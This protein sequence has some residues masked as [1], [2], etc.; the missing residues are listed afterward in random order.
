MRVVESC[1]VAM[2]AVAAC[3]TAC[4]ESPFS[5]VEVEPASRS[6]SPAMPAVLA[7]AAFGPASRVLWPFTGRDFEEPSDPINIIFV[8]QSDPLSLR[9]ALLGLDGDRTAFGLPPASPF[10][11]TWAD[12]IG[13]AQTAFS[14]E[15]GWAGS[16]V[17][18]DCGGYGPL[19]FHLRLFR[20]G[21]WT[22]GGAHFEVL[23]PGTADH[24]VL[25]WELAEQLVVL[26]FMRSGILDPSVPFGA[27]G[28]I[29]PAPSYR[30][31]NPLI[32]NG[33]P[34]ALAAVLGTPP[35]PAA[36]PVPIPNNGVATILNV[37]T[38][39]P[40]TAGVAEQAF[41]LMY[42]VTAP[43]P[44]CASGPQDFIHI[45]GPVSL[46]QTVRVTAAGEYMASARTTGILDV[47]VPGSPSPA[48]TADVDRSTRSLITP[49]G[50][51]IRDRFLQILR[52]SDG[53]TLQSS[54][55][56][57]WLGPG[58]GDFTNI[59]HCN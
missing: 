22:L 20:V 49:A 3:V 7:P 23:I 56:T 54:D 31:I 48:R 52:P 34:A 29:S 27:T 45:R 15:D 26:D 44:F 43:R 28:A 17:Q 33:I 18:L 1:G 55:A 58:G 13:S 12:A 59:L 21:D 4:G 57:L 19:R 11:C 5:E 24:E 36:A 38:A 39:V 14:L 53:G 16:A 9:S 46:Q 8:G 32:Y 30:T 47:T 41:E 50:A 10:D 51:S 25:S 2:V 37:A 40:V 6:V 35:Q 42:D